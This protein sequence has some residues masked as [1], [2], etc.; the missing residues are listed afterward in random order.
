[1][2]P[3]IEAV[4]RLEG[5]LHS[6]LARLEQ[7]LTSNT[8]DSLQIF[9]CYRPGWKDPSIKS[10][11]F[12]QFVLYR[13]SREG[14]CITSPPIV[15]IPDTVWSRRGHCVRF[16]D[17]RTSCFY[18]QIVLECATSGERHFRVAPSKFQE[19]T[20]LAGHTGRAYSSSRGISCKKERI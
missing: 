11:Y 14:P 12:H 5:M 16:W 15:D 3:E 8:I 18:S 6:C 20:S 13:S 4:H 19:H 2:P 9:R 1:M 7:P 10:N 17:R